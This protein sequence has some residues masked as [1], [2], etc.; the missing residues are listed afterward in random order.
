MKTLTHA[1]W[2][3]ALALLAVGTTQAQSKLDVQ[4]SGF[5]TLSASHSD[6]SG[7]DFTATRVQ[8]NGPGR[9]RAVAL[10]TDSRIGA[11]MN[12]RLDDQ[13]EFVAQVVAQQQYDNRFKPAVEW[14]NVGYRFNESLSVRLGRTA[15]PVYLIADS[16]YVGYGMPWVRVPTEVYGTL[17]LTSND[18]LDLTW[19]TR[20]ASYTNTLQLFAGRTALDAPI[21][22]AT[23]QP[24][25]GLADTL[26]M[27]SLTLRG[28]VARYKYNATTPDAEAFQEQADRMI[29]LAASVPLPNFQLAAQQGR[30]L[31]ERFG[32]TDRTMTIGAAGV[33]YDPGPYFL[34]GEVVASR[35]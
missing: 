15:L 34:S 11:Q 27:G 35:N 16:R 32:L 1:R 8:P 24:T 7:A 2:L 4:F 28:S 31:K 29:N 5:G 23:S 6:H 21:G 10:S 12:L 14:L 26:E 30:A 25:M 3:G 18:G 9:S 33:S 20:G 22:R 17:P 19:R 13:F